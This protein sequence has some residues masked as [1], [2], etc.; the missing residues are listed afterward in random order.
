[1]AKIKLYSYF[2]SSASMRVRIALNLKGIDYEY[3]PVDLINGGEQFSSAYRKLNPSCEVPTLVYND[4]AIGQ[5]MAI[6]QFLDRIKPEKPLFPSDPVRYARM[7]QGCEIINSGSQPVQNHRV[8]VQL[9]KVF[10]ATSVQIRNWAAFWIK[11]GLDVLEEFV[12][13][14]AGRFSFGDEISALDCFVVPQMANAQRLEVD[15][16]KYPILC[17]ANEACLK[18]I[19]VQKAAMDVQPDSASKLR[20]PS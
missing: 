10:H 12:A 1:M 13:E 8:D 15:L 4:V 3:C 2:Q 20:S 18:L 5:S 7:V 14:D 9:E 19:E 17:H 6:L 16:M 11:Y